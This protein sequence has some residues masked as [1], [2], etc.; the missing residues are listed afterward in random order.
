MGL[1][2]FPEGLRRAL[3]PTLSNSP[4]IVIIIIIIITVI[5]IV[6]KHSF[7]DNKTQ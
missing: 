7:K 2:L 4:Q 5:V 3:N 1:S 6:I